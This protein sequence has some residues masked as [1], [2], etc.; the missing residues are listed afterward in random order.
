LDI[1]K[2]TVQ[3]SWEPP[4]DDGGSPVTGYIIEKR[5]VSR[6]TWNK[7]SSFFRISTSICYIISACA[8]PFCVLPY[9]GNKF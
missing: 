1:I 9:F 5:E 6:K 3:L 7:V 2:N 4:E 8:T